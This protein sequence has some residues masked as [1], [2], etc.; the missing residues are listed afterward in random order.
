MDL[1]QDCAYSSA[2]VP[3][4]DTMVETIIYTYIYLLQYK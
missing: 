4:M 3:I 2:C 1:H